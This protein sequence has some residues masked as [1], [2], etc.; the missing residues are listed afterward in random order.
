M[1]TVS[2]LSVTLKNRGRSK[3][4]EGRTGPESKGA[5]LAEGI[6]TVKEA[7][8]PPPGEIGQVLIT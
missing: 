2:R 1:Y 8:P 3:K 6:H 5:S 7:V 4:T